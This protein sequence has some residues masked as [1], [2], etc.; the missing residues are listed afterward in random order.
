MS[1][2]LTASLTVEYVPLPPALLP[3]WRQGLANLLEILLA[4]E[5]ETEEKPVE[6]HTPSIPP[7]P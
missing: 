2:K 7:Q 1:K 5:T 6:T 3:A 4:D